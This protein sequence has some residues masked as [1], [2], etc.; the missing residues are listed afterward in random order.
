MG[1]L[2][3]SSTVDSPSVVLQI[4]LVR[5]FD[6]VFQWLEKGSC[7]VD[8]CAVDFRKAFD[9]IRHLTAGM[10]LQENGGPNDAPLALYLTS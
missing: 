4:Y 1:V 8:I 6:C 7:F 3:N 10:N 5:M 2:I 9:I